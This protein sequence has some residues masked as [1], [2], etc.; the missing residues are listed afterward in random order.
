MK[1]DRSAF[2]ILTGKPYGKRSLGRHRRRWEDNIRTDLKEIGVNTRNWI[3]FA[4]NRDYHR[5]LVNS[6]LKLRLPQAMELV[7]VVSYIVSL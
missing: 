3:D 5:V 4:E 6:S 7:T 2:K 1:E